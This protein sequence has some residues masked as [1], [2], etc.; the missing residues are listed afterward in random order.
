ML[1]RQGPLR[2]AY[3]ATTHLN[4]AAMT[5]PVNVHVT[6]GENSREVSIGTGGSIVNVHVAIAKAVS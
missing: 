5:G 3:G 6:F 4:Y 2:V 1:T